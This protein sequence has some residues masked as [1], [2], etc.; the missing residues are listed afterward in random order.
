MPS[1]TEREPVAV[2][3]RTDSPERRVTR[4]AGQQ[5][6]GAG[7]DHDLVVADVAVELIFLNLHGCPY[8]IRMGDECHRSRP[9]QRAGCQR[10][11]AHAERPCPS[12]RVCGN[13]GGRAAFGAG[14]GLTRRSGT[15]E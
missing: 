11:C 9:G 1:R 10:E 3:S 6:Q 8:L 5:G 2:A 12:L 7:L 4:A 13:P 15:G 14:A